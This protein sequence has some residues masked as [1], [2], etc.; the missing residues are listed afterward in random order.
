VGRDAELGIALAFLRG[1][2]DAQARREGNLFIGT[3]AGG[4]TTTTTTTVPT[5]TTTTPGGVSIS[6]PRP[7]GCR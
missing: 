6:A 3:T 4:G 1:E 2:S 7:P 5:T